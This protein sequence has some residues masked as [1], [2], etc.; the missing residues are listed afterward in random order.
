MSPAPSAPQPAAAGPSVTSCFLKTSEPQLV[1]LHLA[2]MYHVKHHE[3]VLVSPFL[4]LTLFG[5]G[6]PFGRFLDRAVE[7]DTLVF[8]ITSSDHDVE[9]LPFFKSLEERGIFVY[10][11]DRLHT[12]LY[13]FDVDLDSRNQWQLGVQSHFIIGSSNLTIPGLGFGDG[14]PNEE[15]NCRVSSELLDDTRTYIERL[16]TQADDFKRFEFKSKRRSR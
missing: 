10:F 8:L 2:A 12:K 11:V 15:L 1:S 6:H 7:E 5:S 14:K 3:I 4:D 16:K 13:Y 9:R